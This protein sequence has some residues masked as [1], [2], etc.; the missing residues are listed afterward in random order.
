MVLRM[1][2]PRV[3]TKGL[4]NCGKDNAHYSFEMLARLDVYPDAYAGPLEKTSVQFSLKSQV[5]MKRMTSTS[6]SP[7]PAPEE[8]ID[9]MAVVFIAYIIPHIQAY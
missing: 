3:S 1:R 2:K 4:E 9:V 5:H 7:D 8:I 6:D